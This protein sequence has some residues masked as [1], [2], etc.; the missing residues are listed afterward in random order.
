[1]VPLVSPAGDFDHYPFRKKIWEDFSS[2]FVER[3]PTEKGFSCQMVVVN[4]S[5]NYSRFSP[6]KHPFMVHSV[7]ERLHGMECPSQFCPTAI[8]FSQL[9]CRKSFSPTRKTKTDG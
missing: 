9:P 7:A 3:L 1:M 4:R 5:S 6:L 8:R 2:D